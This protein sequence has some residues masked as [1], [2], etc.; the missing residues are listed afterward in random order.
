M[1]L[2]VEFLTRE[3]YEAMKVRFKEGSETVQQEETDLIPRIKH[4]SRF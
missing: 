4:L 3:C 1:H 2:L